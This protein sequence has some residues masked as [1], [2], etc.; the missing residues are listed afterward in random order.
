MLESVPLPPDE[1]PMPPATVN[2]IHILA[3][4]MF[5]QAE[6][7]YINRRAGEIVVAMMK[8]RY[9]EDFAK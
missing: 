6:R 5:E 9:G 8:A 1:P 7:D 3:G 4:I 2:R